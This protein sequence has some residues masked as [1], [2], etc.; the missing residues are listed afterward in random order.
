MVREITS[1]KARLPII[2]SGTLRPLPDL[3]HLLSCRWQ[4]FF[5]DA[6]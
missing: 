5:G 2:M 6:G 4:N 1:D 3:I